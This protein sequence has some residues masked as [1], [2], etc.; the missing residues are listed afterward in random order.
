MSGSQ[1]KNIKCDTCG[2]AVAIPYWYSEDRPCVLCEKG[3]M[4]LIPEPT[5]KEVQEIQGRRESAEQGEQALRHVDEGD[6]ERARVAA[7]L[8]ARK[9]GPIVWTLKEMIEGKRKVK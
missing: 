7:A 1:T 3:K 2:A 9:A 6:P 4:I 8:A 5:A